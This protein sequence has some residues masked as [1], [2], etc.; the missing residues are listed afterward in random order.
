[1]LR[2]LNIGS[3]G[4]VSGLSPIWITPAQAKNNIMIL[5]DNNRITKNMVLPLWL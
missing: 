4:R 2:T 1:M 5:Q 3:V